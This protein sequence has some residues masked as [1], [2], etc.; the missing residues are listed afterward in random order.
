MKKLFVIGIVLMF[1]V[2]CQK[3]S[4]IFPT[5]NIELQLNIISQKKVVIL[6]SSL[7]IGDYLNV[8]YSIKNLSIKSCSYYKI[9]FEAIPMSGG[10]GIYQNDGS[11]CNI[12]KDS[13]I[14]DSILIKIPDIKEDYVA[15][16]IDYIGE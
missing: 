6:K 1:S 12:Q 13:T 5:N 15:R 4:I 14:M 7:V 11:Y 2:S 8:K 3:E 9:N 10:F 16:I